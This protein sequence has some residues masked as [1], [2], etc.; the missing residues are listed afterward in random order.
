[1]SQVKEFCRKGG[2]G[3]VQK[4]KLGG[5][6]GGGDKRQEKEQSGSQRFQHWRSRVG[7]SGA[8]WGGVGRSGVGGGGSVKV[9]D[10]SNPLWMDYRRLGYTDFG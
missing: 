8:E 10:R 1:M 4:S 5:G 3:G 6:G 7:W 9:K 2:G